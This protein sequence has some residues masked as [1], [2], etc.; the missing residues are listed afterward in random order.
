MYFKLTYGYR[1]TP[2]SRSTLTKTTLPQ[3]FASVKSQ[4]EGI[5]AKQSFFFATVDIW[6]DRAMRSYLGITA[7]TITTDEVTKEMNLRSFLLKF[8]RLN[9]SHTAEKFSEAFHNAMDNDNLKNKLEI[10]VTDNAANM[11]AAFKT[12]FS[13]IRHSESE[14][15]ESEDDNENFQTVESGNDDT[16][17]ATLQLFSEERIPCFAHTL[18]LTV[19]DGLKETNNLDGSLGKVSRLAALLHRS[20]I[21]KER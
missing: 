13:G 1:Y 19:K 6:T 10:I 15:E 16:I 5:L 2:M 9:G 20:T 3:M 11:R 4:V 21:F 17:D 12:S 14:N 8:Q 7:H 18:Q